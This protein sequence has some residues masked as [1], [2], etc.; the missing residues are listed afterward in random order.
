MALKV[1]FAVP[2]YNGS[3]YIRDVLEAVK[4]QTIQPHEIIVVDDGS[5]DGTRDMVSGIEGV[6]LVEKPHTGLSDTRNRAIREARGEFICFLD[7][8]IVLESNWLEE[9]FRNTDFKDVSAAT[10]YVDTLNKD[11]SIFCMM[12]EK[13]LRAVFTGEPQ[14]FSMGNR[15]VNYFN[16]VFK[17][18]VFD[19]VGGFDVMFK[20][21]GE[22][23]EFFYRF[24]SKGMKVKYVP[25]AVAHHIYLIDSAYA[26]FRKRMNYGGSALTDVMYHVGWKRKA[27]HYG[28]VFG[29]FACLPLL[30]IEPLIPIFLTLSFLLFVLRRGYRMMGSIPL[31]LVYAATVCFEQVGRVRETVKWHLGVYRR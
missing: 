20:T 13:T 11:K 24:F 31:T 30:F 21:N 17:R 23:I 3:R 1:T 16:Y 10:G 28:R 5:T 6:R 2:V 29:F 12:D 25:S 15:R 7:S 26:W 4:S 9:I 14:V 18:E 8:D 19:M 22:D 27:W